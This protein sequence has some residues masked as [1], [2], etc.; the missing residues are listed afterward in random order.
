M[1]GSGGGGL[2]EE[3]NSR[4]TWRKPLRTSSSITPERR[5]AADVCCANIC[6]VQSESLLDTFSFPSVYAADV[7][8]S[9][10]FAG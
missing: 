6:G 3:R 7:N 5:N 8:M 2:V 9:L 1:E 4:K 10:S